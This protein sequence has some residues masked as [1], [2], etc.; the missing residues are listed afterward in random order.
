MAECSPNSGFEKSFPLRDSG[1]NI[2]PFRATQIWNEIIYH[3]KSRVEVKRRRLKMRS[4]DNCFTGTDAVD[5]VLHYLLNDKETFN[6]EL[7]REKAIKLCQTLM[8]KSVFEPANCRPVDGKPVFEDS[9]SKLYRFPGSLEDDKENKDSDED[10]NQSEMCMFDPVEEAEYL[11]K[12][13]PLRVNPAFEP[14]VSSDSVICNPA[15]I[16]RSGSVM[17]ELMKISSTIKCKSAMSLEPRRI[18]T[19]MTRN[20]DIQEV[21]PEV[22]E[23]TWKEVALAQLL[24]L[25]E[26]PFLDGVLGEEKE[27]K[28]QLRRNLIIS[29]VVAKHTNMPFL[30]AVDFED[31]VMHTAYDCL[32]CMPKGTSLLSDESFK[33]GDAQTKT[34]L[35]WKIAKYYSE[36]SEPLLP[37]RFIDLHVA[38]LNLIM[39]EH[40]KNALESLQ[41][42]VILLPWSVREELQRLLRFLSAVKKDK[43]FSLDVQESNK[44]IVLKVFCDSI[45]KHKLL[46]SSVAA[47]FVLFLLSHHREIFH[48]P[49]N[50]REKVSLRL[51][52]LKHGDCMPLYESTYCNRITKE[53]YQRQSE[54]CTQSSLIEMINS[55]LDDVNIPLKDKK[56]RL[57]QFQKYY[58]NIYE[59]YFQGMI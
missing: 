13:K 42:D 50:I 19:K 39:T 26:V 20:S 3:L 32:Q 54:E 21:S 16:G 48:V 40:E 22:V 51:Y 55:V 10:L 34:K 38:I 12:S 45:L 58:P 9:S 59:R 7:S 27:N 56:V 35:F 46:T 29:N 15:L 23:E 31:S 8:N 24:I 11:K 6:T 4:Y 44:T 52:K 17:E 28:K 57:R 18:D 36:L 49:R 1:G 25:V 30:G 47:E 33:Q 2:G 37:E 43:S 14:D 5:V 53:E 41:L